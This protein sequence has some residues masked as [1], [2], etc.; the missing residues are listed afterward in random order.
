MRCEFYLVGF[1]NNR[2]RQNDL[3][4][5]RSYAFPLY[6]IV[7]TFSDKEHVT[8]WALSKPPQSWQGHDLIPSYC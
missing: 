2:R 4:D 7:Q 1:E 3:V 8:L 6:N 5:D